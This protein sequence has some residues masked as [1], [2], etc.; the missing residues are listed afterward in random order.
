MWCLVAQCVDTRARGEVEAG[1]DRGGDRSRDLMPMKMGLGRSLQP[2]R[3][4]HFM[5][6]F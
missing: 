6:K 1:T 4:Q 5:L 3:A 2:L